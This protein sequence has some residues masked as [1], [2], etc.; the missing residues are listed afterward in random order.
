MRQR[1]QITGVDSIDNRFPTTCA[2][3]PAT[4]IFGDFVSFRLLLS[5]CKQRFYKKTFPGSGC[6]RADL[7]A[8]YR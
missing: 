6:A 8:R 5:R 3:A 4:W 1:F 7:G 2:C